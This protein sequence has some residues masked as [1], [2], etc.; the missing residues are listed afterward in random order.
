M[1]NAR[2]GYTVIEVLLVL[3]ISSTL[4]FAAILAF[5]GRQSSTEFTQAVQDLASK[6]QS[7]ASDITT[8]VVPNTGTDGC[9]ES[10]GKPK[11]NANTD[12]NGGCTYL[13]RALLVS[14][15]SSFDDSI[16]AYAVFG[17]TGDV[18]NITDTFNPD[19]ISTATHGND[20]LFLDKYDLGNLTILSSHVE[21]GDPSKD[22]GLIGLY[23]DLAGTEA[24]DTSNS[25]GL[26]TM[27]YQFQT[28][29]NNDNQL[30]KDVRD[31]VGGNSGD[32]GDCSQATT[33]PTK[34]FSKWTLCVQYAGGPTAQIISRPTASS[35]ST[36]VNVTD[37]E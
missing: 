21:G 30:S 31:C 6:I 2:G 5:S 16:S 27:G 22:Y 33:A 10:G 36:E 24:P 8:G 13:G 25:T 7:Y 35:L 29:A 17:L 9:R 37:C 28:H 20:D 23:S 1:R 32:F 34:N 11:F 4:L 14:N 3:A 18:D 26:L 15:D 12:N 19:N